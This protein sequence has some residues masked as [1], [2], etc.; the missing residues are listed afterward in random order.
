MEIVRS[1][2]GRAARPTVAIR[3]D[4]DRAIWAEEDPVTGPDI[5]DPRVRAE[6]RRLARDQDIQLHRLLLAAG[7]HVV[8]W[9]T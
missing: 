3:P 8:Q 1:T 5:R 2:S 6:V 7:L 4:R 9:E